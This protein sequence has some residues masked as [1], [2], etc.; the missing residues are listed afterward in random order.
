MGRGYWTFFT[1]KEPV[2]VVP[3]FFS[4]FSFHQPWNRTKQNKTKTLRANKVTTIA[5]AR[6]NPKLKWNDSKSANKIWRCHV[7]CI[8]LGKRY[9]MCCYQRKVGGRGK[10]EWRDKERES[11]LGECFSAGTLIVFGVTW[12]IVFYKYNEG[13]WQALKNVLDFSWLLVHFTPTSKIP[14]VLNFFERRFFS[15]YS[16]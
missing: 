3:V 10:K 1:L 11:C 12:S 9:F 6:T 5:A 13:F 16:S 7:A 4:L 15:C 2:C 14:N 8:T